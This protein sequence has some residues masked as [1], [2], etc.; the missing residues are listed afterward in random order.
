MEQEVKEEEIIIMITIL[1]PKCNSEITTKE[2]ISLLVLLKIKTTGVKS[3]TIRTSN[4][5]A[6]L[7]TIILISR[8]IP[9]IHDC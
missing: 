8:I 5:L 6:I 4:N 9:I 7:T 1:V 3:Q 2:T